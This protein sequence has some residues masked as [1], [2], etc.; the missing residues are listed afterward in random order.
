MPCY[1]PPVNRPESDLHNSELAQM[2][3]EVMRVIERNGLEPYVSRAVND[4]WRE[5]QERDRARGVA[6]P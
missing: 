2:L 5:H 6:R 1:D 4:W 3:C